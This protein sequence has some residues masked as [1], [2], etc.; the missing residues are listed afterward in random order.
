M[1]KGLDKKDRFGRSTVETII[2]F[3]LIF[4]FIILVIQIILRL[5]TNYYSLSLI[6]LSEKISF[7]DGL[8]RKIKVIYEEIFQ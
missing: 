8:E 4:I 6:S 1:K 3:P 7:L 2:V 5:S